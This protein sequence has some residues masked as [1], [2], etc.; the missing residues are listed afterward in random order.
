MFQVTAALA[1]CWMSKMEPRVGWH[2][3]V[4]IS[5]AISKRYKTKGSTTPQ[6]KT[7]PGQGTQ[8]RP[9]PFMLFRYK[10]ALI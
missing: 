8:N 9:F 10:N 2:P 1:W 6:N 3:L 4:F 7:G 5:L